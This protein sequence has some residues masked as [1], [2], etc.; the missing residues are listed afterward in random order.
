VAGADDDV[1][2]KSNP[3][4][5]LIIAHALPMLPRKFLRRRVAASIRSYPQDVRGLSSI[6]R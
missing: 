6:P 1:A 3:K 5:M 2:N 4:K